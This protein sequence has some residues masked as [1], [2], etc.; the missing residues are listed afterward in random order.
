[1]FKNTKGRVVTLCVFLTFVVGIAFYIHQQSKPVPEPIKSDKT[2][3]PQSKQAVPVETLQGE[4]TPEELK[5]PAAADVHI[6]H[7]YLLHRHS[8]DLS[9]AEPSPVET[10]DAEKISTVVSTD[11]NAKVLSEEAIQKWVTETMKVLDDLNTR[12]LEKYPALFEIGNMTREDFFEK[13]PTVESRQALLEYVQSVQ[14]EMFAELHTVFSN[15]PIEIADDIL[16]KTKDHFIQM[17]G[18]ETADQ[19]MIKLRAELGL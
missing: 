2:P 5:P 19:V 6:E 9:E 12:F 16:L 14:P 13:Y 4:T 15:L 18:T 11:E 7:S 3:G 17:W 8:P 10:P 1:M